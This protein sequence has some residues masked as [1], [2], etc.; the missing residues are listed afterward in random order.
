MYSG[1]LEEI[2]R[3]ALELVDEFV[4]KEE[5]ITTL[6]YYI[7][8]VSVRRDRPR[9]GSPRYRMQVPFF[10][11]GPGDSVLQGQ[12]SDLSRDG[13]S[14][15]LQGARE[16]GTL[17]RLEIRLP[18]EVAVHTRAIVR[19]KV[20]ARYGF[21]FLDPTTIEIQSIKSFPTA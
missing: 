3:R 15:V 5:P 2:P 21:Q 19:H 16:P 18:S 9:R 6:F 10:A 8:R 20:G 4:S 14:G 17:V 1:G 11:F 13:M 7:P 12:S